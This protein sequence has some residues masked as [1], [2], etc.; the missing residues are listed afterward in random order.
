MPTNL[1]FLM[2]NIDFEILHHVCP[3]YNLGYSLSTEY[4]IGRAL[5][6]K[7]LPSQLF[8]KAQRC[9]GLQKKMVGSQVQQGGPFIH[10]RL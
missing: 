10:L 3:I 2:F 1:F 9:F 6:Q 4:V 5:L 7:S 8:Y